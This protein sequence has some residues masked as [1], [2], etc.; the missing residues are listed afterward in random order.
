MANDSINY[1]HEPDFPAGG[2]GKL[3]RQ[4]FRDFAS[5]PLLTPDEEVDLSRRIKSGDKAAYDQ[6]VRA[7]LR[8]VVK[9]AWQCRGSRRG[10]PIL[11]LIQEGNLGLMR[12]AEDFDGE[13]GC[14]CA[15]YAGW[16]VWRSHPGGPFAGSG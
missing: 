10:V 3:L 11:D 5:I 1:T 9:I 6:L 4:Y 8:L 7:N 2:E 14:P 13:R 12:A 16:G 15:T